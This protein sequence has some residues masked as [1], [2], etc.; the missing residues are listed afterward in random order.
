M[1]DSHSKILYDHL[2]G[3]SVHCR[4]GEQEEER[5]GN[6]LKVKM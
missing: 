2:T 1:I 4:A 5:G 3:A 6:G